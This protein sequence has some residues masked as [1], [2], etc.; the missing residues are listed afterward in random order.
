VFDQHEP[1]REVAA[2]FASGPEGSQDPVV[3]ELEDS[4]LERIAGFLD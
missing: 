4:E 3:A 1:D 2:S